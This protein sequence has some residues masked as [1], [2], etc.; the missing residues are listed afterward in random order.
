[1]GASHSKREEDV[2]CDKRSMS[3]WKGP[4]GSCT[5]SY[6]PVFYLLAPFVLVM[7]REQEG[8][9]GWGRTH[10]QCVRE[11]GR[12]RSERVRLVVIHQHD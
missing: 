10:T 4:K 6:L 2:I 1:M 12:S 8:E 7:F 9:G 5:D 3:G 11:Y